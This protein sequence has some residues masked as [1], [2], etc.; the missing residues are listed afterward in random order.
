MHEER[1]IEAICRRFHGIDCKPGLCY[2]LNSHL[3][4]EPFRETTAENG[5]HIRETHLF[6]ANRQ[7]RGYWW[8]AA[9]GPYCAKKPCERTHVAIFCAKDVKSGEQNP[10]RLTRCHLHQ[11]HHHATAKVHRIRTTRPPRRWLSTCT[12]RFAED[13]HTDE[14]QHEERARNGKTPSL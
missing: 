11:A 12:G 2:F 13:Q 1:I 3:G 9:S 14:E 10:P 6:G 7:Q 5:A 8:T 4:E